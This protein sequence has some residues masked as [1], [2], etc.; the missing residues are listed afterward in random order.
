MHRRAQGGGGGQGNLSAAAPTMHSRWPPRHA[1]A[2]RPAPQQ[3]GCHTQLGSDCARHLS[4]ACQPSAAVVVVERDA[5]AAPGVWACAI[6][7]GRA[8]WARG[9]EAGVRAVS[10][11]GVWWEAPQARGPWTTPHPPIQ[12]VSRAQLPAACPHGCMAHCACGAVQCAPGS[13]CLVGCTRVASSLIG[14][15][16][17]LAAEERSSRSDHG[18]RP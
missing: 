14:C 8:C 6:G 15:R 18:L 1:A 17:H 5:V 2:A 11:Q 12:A 3:T 4:D 9:A 16:S 13:P 7:G 10:E